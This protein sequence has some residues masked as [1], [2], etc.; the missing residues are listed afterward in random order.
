MSNG[1]CHITGPKAAD[2]EPL[3]AGQH[4]ANIRGNLI[5]H[6]FQKSAESLRHIAKCL[7]KEPLFVKI[8]INLKRNQRVKARRRLIQRIFKVEKAERAKIVTMTIVKW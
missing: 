1:E 7:L 2:T 4:R 6:I 3:L 8:I 5:A